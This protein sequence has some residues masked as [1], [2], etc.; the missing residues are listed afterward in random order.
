MKFLSC[1][2]IAGIFVLLTPQRSEAVEPVN[3]GDR[4]PRFSAPA[5]DG[6]QWKS[7]DHVGKK[8]L[9]VYFYPADL[10]GGCTRQACQ[11]R[12]DR[13]KLTELGADVVGV[14]GDTVENHQVFRDAHNL[15][16]PLLADVDG[17]V[18]QAFGVP[19]TVEEKEATVKVGDREL[20]LTRLATAK[21]WTFVIDRDGKVV[22]KNESVKPE[23]DSRE[24]IEV[25]QKLKS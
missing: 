25:I 21:R 10:T 18:A 13:T 17:K 24:V 8:I 15:N 2:A 22:Y 14:S 3:V 11:F 12:D 19:V 1:L 5:D 9:V 16:F 4:A 6:T 23:Q 20:T 7:E